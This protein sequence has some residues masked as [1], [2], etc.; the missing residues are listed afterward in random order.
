MIARRREARIVAITV[1]SRALR[2]AAE[3]LG[4][5]KRLAE[6]LGVEVEDIEK[7]SAGT[8]RTPREIFLRV[9]DLILDE[10]PSPADS[11]DPPSEPP[12]TPSSAPI[13]R[14]GSE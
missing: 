6:R 12:P 8:R 2:K 14:R 11:S 3:L 10:L 5:Q 9:G 1:Q 4:G 13:S 7:W